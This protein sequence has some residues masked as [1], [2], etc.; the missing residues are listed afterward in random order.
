MEKTAVQRLAVVLRTMVLVV[1]VLNLL[2]LLLVPGFA[3]LVADR[4]LGRLLAYLR[5]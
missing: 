2:C 1:F 5:E 4:E 3:G